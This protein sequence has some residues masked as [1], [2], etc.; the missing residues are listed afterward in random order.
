MSMTPEEMR[1]AEKA[2][3]DITDAIIRNH[4]GC[5]AWPASQRQQVIWTVHEALCRT[6]WPEK[7]G[8]K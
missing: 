2:A 5:V 8:N 4:G 7:W 1:V 3:A 6:L